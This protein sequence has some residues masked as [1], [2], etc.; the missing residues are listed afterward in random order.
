MKNY[1]EMLCL[2]D[3]MNKKIQFMFL[4][5]VFFIFSA[6]VA[7]ASVTIDIEIKPEFRLGEK[8]SFSYTFL[9]D[10][11]EEVSYAAS[12]NCPEA[13][14]PLLEIKYA[15]LEKDTPFKEE[16]VFM[17]VREE[18]EPQNC[19]AIVAIGESFELSKEEKFEIITN[20]SFEFNVISCKDQLCSEQTK[21]FVKGKTI[22]L[23]YSSNVGKP[24]IT[25]LL[26]NPDKTTEQIT[27]P[28][29][30]K[31]KQIGTYNLEAVAS[32]QGYKTM[33]KKVQF[34]VIEEEADIPYLGKDKKEEEGINLT[35]II[36]IVLSVIIVVVVIFNI[37]RRRK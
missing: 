20:P 22:Y 32:K 26:T 5:L 19:T 2:E 31:A 24:S 30:I 7:S 8:V 36:L 34:G 4:A 13:P 33:T 27:L 35:S 16:Y 21:V 12:V 15:T 9:S 18:I 11:D 6:A 29:S 3:K 10:V 28:T 1:R 14:L 17:E 37:Y 25:A 23:D